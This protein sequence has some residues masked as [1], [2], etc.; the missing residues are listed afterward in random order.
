MSLDDKEEMISSMKSTIIEL[1]GQLEKSNTPPQNND[2]KSENLKEILKK[3]EDTINELS[4]KVINLNNLLQRYVEM[5]SRKTLI[6]PIN[7]DYKLKHIKELNNDKEKH[8][9]DNISQSKNSNELNDNILSNEYVKS[10]E[11]LKSNEYIKSNENDK[12]NDYIKT[13][14]NDKLC[15]KEQYDEK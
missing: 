8:S 9:H 4:S 5:E 6:D 12:S 11:N 13:N 14:E 2:S 3:K 15:N 7:F 10:C 1:Q